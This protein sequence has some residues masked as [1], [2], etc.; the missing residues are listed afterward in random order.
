MDENYYTHQIGSASQPF[1][2][3]PLRQRGAGIGAILT[4]VKQFAIPLARRYVIP[5]G[6][7]LLRNAVPEILDIIAGKTKPKRAFKNA[8]RKTV[9]KQMGGGRSR[10]KSRKKQ[11]KPKRKTKKKPARKRKAVKKMS[12]SK[13]PSVAKK[14]GQNKIITK[15]K[16]KG[17]SRKDF[18]SSVVD[19]SSNQ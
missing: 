16:G 12:S 5:A 19:L 13:R 14:R 11:S 18:F 3:G 4:G 9:L 1:F 2:Q 10:A 17:R 7:E 8:A 15:R 6:R